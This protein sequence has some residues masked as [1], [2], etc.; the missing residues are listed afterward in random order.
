[1]SLDKSG[2]VMYRLIGEVCCSPALD[3]FGSGKGV[4]NSQTASSAQGHFLDSMN[5]H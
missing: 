5:K 4:S 1:M 2:Y 3:C